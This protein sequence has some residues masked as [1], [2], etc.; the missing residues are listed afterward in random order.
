MT[1]TINIR[2]PFVVPILPA[3]E[4]DL[5]NLGHG[6][7]DPSKVAIA[8]EMEED[9]SDR[10]GLTI[11]EL[12]FPWG[13][14]AVYGHDWDAVLALQRV[15]S[16][17]KRLLVEEPDGAP[18]GLLGP[19]VGILGVRNGL[20]ENGQLGTLSVVKSL[21][22]ASRFKFP[23]V[24]SVFG[25]LRF[26]VIE[27]MEQ[28]NLALKVALVEAMSDEDEN[29]DEE[30]DRLAAHLVE[31]LVELLVETKRFHQRSSQDSLMAF[32]WGQAIERKMELL[33]ELLD[34]NQSLD[35]GMN[36]MEE[37]FRWD[38]SDNELLSFFASDLLD[39]SLQQRLKVFQSTST[40]E[41]LKLALRGVGF[42]L[43]ELKGTEGW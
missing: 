10:P 21:R 34:S 36:E 14:G 4:K 22:A 13:T 38:N 29:C 25:F 28:T 37:K 16:L 1:E 39:L 11:N 41:R 3:M 18:Y 23:V 43:R 35:E 9:E 8:D 24:L 33:E 12:L 40:K 20:V 6:W 5:R 17:P 31:Y 42:Q 15:C 7:N 30:N 27:V 19:V 2:E 32:Q 26:R